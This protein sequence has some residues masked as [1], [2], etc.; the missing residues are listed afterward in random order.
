MTARAFRYITTKWQGGC[1]RCHAN[2]LKGTGAYYRKP[3]LFCSQA[4]A[5]TL[6]VSRIQE[7]GT[8][9]ESED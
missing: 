1:A 5:T 9:R 7:I 8:Q 3:D 2:I 6:T 4:C